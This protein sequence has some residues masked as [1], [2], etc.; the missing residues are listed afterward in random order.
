MAQPTPVPSPF[1]IIHVLRMCRKMEE[2]REG[3]GLGTRLALEG[4]LNE[5]NLWSKEL[6]VNDIHYRVVVAK[7]M[8]TISMQQ[9][10]WQPNC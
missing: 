6:C 2:G 4:S 8:A 7:C 9:V 5:N 10:T 1:R 3:K